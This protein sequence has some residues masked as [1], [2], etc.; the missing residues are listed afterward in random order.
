MVPSAFVLLE[1][2]PLTPNGK[3][4]RRGLPAPDISAASD[5]TFVPPSSPTE[6][7]LAAIW[8]Q[9]LVRKKIGIYDNFFELGGHSLK[10]TQVICRIQEVFSVELP[11]RHLFEA[12]TVAELAQVIETA[13]Q[14]AGNVPA[15]T[16]TPRTADVKLALSFAQERLWFLDRLEGKSATYNIASAWRLEGKLSVES[17]EL[18]LEEII[19]RHEIL[20]TRFTSENGVPIQ[21]IASTTPTPLSLM[22]LQQLPEAQREAEVQRLVIQEA[23]KPFDLEFVPL[24][25]VTLLQLNCQSHVLMLTMHHIIS[26]GWSM[27]VLW[28]S[29]S[30]LYEARSS[31]QKSP[32]ADLLIQYADYALWPREWFQGNLKET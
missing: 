17:L 10:A 12:P 14:T 5:T 29:L 19:S 28:H 16:I 11:L 32:D 13:R 22:D 7:L 15:S 24:L 6:E 27:G 20:R 3:V 8:S 2:M 4:D 31:G 21:V 18:A 26:D 30:A 9:V 1:A 23:Q 25:R